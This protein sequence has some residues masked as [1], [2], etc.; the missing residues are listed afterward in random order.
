MAARDIR[1]LAG[2][3]EAVICRDSGYFPVIVNPSGENLFVVMRAG[4]GHVG[5]AGRL[6]GVLSHDCGKTW[7]APFTI[8]DS[9]VDD[10]NPALGQALDG[11]L[12]LAY[13]EQGSYLED[14]SWASHLEMVRMMVTRSMDG[15][16]TWETP[17]EMGVPALEKH[18]AFGHIVT[19]EDG[20]MLMP[21]YGHDIT[22]GEGS[23]AYVLRS[24]DSGISWCDPSLIAAEYNETALLLLPGGELLAAMRSQEEGLLALSRS[25]DGG[26]TWDTPVHVTDAREHPAD[27]TLLSNNWVLMMFGVR[28]EPFGVQAMVSKDQ[29]STWEERLVVRDNLGERDLG[30]PS[31]VAVGDRLVTV[32]Y[33]APRIFGDPAYLGKGAFASV[34]RYSEKALVGELSR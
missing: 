16:S 31:T 30:Y 10:R 8:V 29:G 32:Y 33:S 5:I 9:K 23:S 12:V 13:H 34:L 11:A 14:G 6:E 24:S 22:S 1:R 18:S 3:E 19:L 7:D 21:I 17:I 2:S 27:L 20:T 26:Y 15:G 4:A 25:S 28:H